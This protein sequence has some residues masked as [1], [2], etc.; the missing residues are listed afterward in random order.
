MEDKKFIFIFLTSIFLL[1]GLLCAQESLLEIKSGYFID[2][3]KGESVFKQRLVW[4]EDEYA[5]YYEVAIQQFSTQY[6]D[7]YTKTTNEAFIE[8]S[9]RPGRYRY[10]VTPYD[11]LGRRCESSDW[12]EFT[13]EQAFQPEIIKT[14]PEFFYM[15]QTK[16]RVLLISGNNIFD[17][18]DIYLINGENILFPVNKIITNNS[19]VKLTFNDDLLIPGTYDIYIKNPGGLDVV[20]GGFFIGYNRRYETFLK[21]GF[22]PVI[23]LSGGFNDIFGSYFYYPGATFRLESL[24]SAR[25]SFKTGLEF[26]VSLYHLNNDYCIK[27]L[28]SKSKDGTFTDAKLTLFDF[29]LNVSFQTRYN[30]LKNAIT[31][32]FGFGVTNSKIEDFYSD[33]TDDPY[34]IT[35]NTYNNDYNYNGINVHANLGLSAL[36]LIYK[37]FYI[38][39]GVELTYYLI[40]SSVLIKP[41]ISLV[42]RI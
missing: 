12:E 30:H 16:E 25:A 5:S 26:A 3:N 17:D 31:F 18:S 38:E 15:D 29:S 20:K 6:N 41:K 35:Y 36:F 8:I 13:I 21:L 9:L 27:P 33:Y 4:D 34:N 10:S 23:P 28:D 19:S 11:L 42:L 22:N 40:G 7:Y 37:D 14:V 24:S 1:S 2:K 32:S 39:T